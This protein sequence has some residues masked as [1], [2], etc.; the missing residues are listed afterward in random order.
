MLEGEETFQLELTGATNATVDA[1][2]DTT[3]V[4]IVEQPTLSISD[5]NVDEDVAGG[6]ATLTIELKPV[7]SAL[8][9]V[10][11]TASTEIGDT[12][13]ANVDYTAVS[14]QAS[15]PAGSTST[16]VNIPITN[17]ALNE[18]PENFSV[19][20][21]NP[22]GTDAVLG[23]AILG[24]DVAW[25]T[26]V[27]DDPLPVVSINPATDSIDEDGGSVSLA[28]DLA[29]VSGR[30]VMVNYGTADVTATGGAD[31]V[32]MNGTATISEGSTTAT[33]T[34]DVEVLDDSIVEPDET[35]QVILSGPVYA[36]ISL[37]N[38]S[39]TI[40][41]VDDALLINVSIDDAM[42]LESAGNAMLEISQDLVSSADVDVEYRTLDG[43]ALASSDYT[44]VTTSTATITAGSTSTMVA[45]PLTNDTDEEDAETVIVKLSGVTTPGDIDAAIDDG[46]GVLTIK[47]DDGPAAKIVTIT[48]Y[49]EAMASDQYFVVLAGD[50]P[51]FGAITNVTVA[52]TTNIGEMVPIAQ[53]PEVLVKMHGL[54]EVRSKPATHVWLAMVPYGQP[55]GTIDFQFT[56]DYSGGQAGTTASLDV[57][58]A[59]TN[60]NFFLFPGVNY[61]GLGLVPDDT[62]IADLLDQTVGNVDPDFIDALKDLDP[63]S[64]A[65]DRDVATLGDVVETVFA[66][67]FDSD[68]GFISYS[69][70]DPFASLAPANG[71][72]TDLDPIQGMLV[73]TRETVADNGDTI[74]VFDT[75]WQPGY[76]DADVP[77]KMTIWGPFVDTEVASPSKTLRVGFNLVAPHVSADTPFDTAF[78]GS[79]LPVG[80]LYGSAI[81]RW[82]DVAAWDGSITAEI[83]DT[84]VAESAAIAPFVEPGTISAEQSYWLRVAATNPQI[85]PTLTASG[86]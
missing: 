83:I 2:N 31:Y 76:G 9:T 23:D 59:R 11:Y 82:R 1:G 46:T 37:T 3:V 8:T 75:A 68:G 69:S 86:P 43:T 45:V 85:T 19:T 47:D 50:H 30:D 36:T 16:T 32:S 10:T 4:S 48:S 18:N 55:Q 84:W 56:V 66:F 13:T 57:V 77:V 64:E 14:A 34:V 28:I 21:T 26:I 71:G 35:L 40:T 73:K 49:G 38:D 33:M 60:R 20:L 72:L 25:V 15:I 52:T 62:S 61:T 41:I 6:N 44:E 42:Y 58:G 78:G 22:Q 27:D 79:G 65:L 17:D 12:A 39:S 63:D 24:I 51:T 80:V 54:G 81:T 53:V 67:E 29:P 5:V 7:S 70:P 74:A